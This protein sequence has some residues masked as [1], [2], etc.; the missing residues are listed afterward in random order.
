MIAISLATRMSYGG[1]DDIWLKRDAFD[2]DLLYMTPVI[3]VC[4]ADAAISLKNVSTYIS[5]LS[6]FPGDPHGCTCTV[7]LLG[8]QINRG[9]EEH[10]RTCAHKLHVRLHKGRWHLVEIAPINHRQVEILSV[11]NTCSQMCSCNHKRARPL[12]RMDLF[13]KPSSRL[14][15]AFSKHKLQVPFCPFHRI[16]SAVLADSEH[17]AFLWFENSKKTKKNKTPSTM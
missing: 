7:G 14:T 16:K 12:S 9:A 8:L 17:I 6:A 1:G 4:G 3:S 13:V 11:S 2:R 15:N 10:A 5:F